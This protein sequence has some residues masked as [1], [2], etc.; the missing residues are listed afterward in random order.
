MKQNLL[1]TSNKNDEEAKGAST[2]LREN[3]LCRHFQWVEDVN[4]YESHYSISM[5]MLHGVNAN[6]ES[7]FTGS[8]AISQ[9]L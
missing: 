9:I 6:F 5:L 7:F 4:S 1:L 2:L 3:D 8:V